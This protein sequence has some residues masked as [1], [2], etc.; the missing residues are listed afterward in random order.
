MKVLTLFCLSQLLVG[1]FA[2]PTESSP[3]QSCA[4]LRGCGP[5]EL[6]HVPTNRCHPQGQRGPCKETQ[7]LDLG[8][9]PCHGVCRRTSNSGLANPHTDDST[10][11]YPVNQ[12][13]NPR[14]NN[15][16]CPPKYRLSR[17]GQCQRVLTKVEEAAIVNRVLARNRNR[18][19]AS[20]TNLQSTTTAPVSDV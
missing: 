17:N 9:N 20:S 7:I 12:P 8:R 5:N 3:S 15:R 1:S 13:S 18:Q 4:E 6:F 10:I 14:R 19:E 16:P 11:S 2:L